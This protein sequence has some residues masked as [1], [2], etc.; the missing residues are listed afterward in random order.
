MA[1]LGPVHQVAAVKNRDAGKVGE[2]GVDQVIVITDP[3]DAGV[4]VKTRN[5]GVCK[6]HVDNLFKEK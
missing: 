2:C 6:A 1:E 3:A 5:N 4:G